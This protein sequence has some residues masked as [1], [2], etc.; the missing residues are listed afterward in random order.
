MDDGGQERMY[1]G[2]NTLAGGYGIT[3]TTPDG[4]LSGNLAMSAS[5]EGGP[6]DGMQMALG[7]LVILIASR[8]ITSLTPHQPGA[9]PV[10]GASLWP[11]LLTI[12]NVA[13]RTIWRA[14]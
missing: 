3:F 13:G 6:Q 11:D 1:I 2:P 9:P 7:D 4:K 12:Q 10:T 14:P 8:Q 5:Q